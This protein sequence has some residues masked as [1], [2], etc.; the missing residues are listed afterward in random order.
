[1]TGYQQ[2]N[3]PGQ[4]QRMRILVEFSTGN[5]FKRMIEIKQTESEISR[6]GDGLIL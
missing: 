1:M 4:E 3:N 6:V 5:L 2:K